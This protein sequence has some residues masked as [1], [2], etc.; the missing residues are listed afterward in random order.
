MIEDN[1]CLLKKSESTRSEKVLEVK[2]NNVR[3]QLAVEAFI[4]CC[5]D[6][7]MHVVKVV[8]GLDYCQNDVA[9]DSGIAAYLLSYRYH[10]A[11]IHG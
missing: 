5:R 6:G 3:I 10:T 9:H 1:V 2:N 4:M 11:I 7:W 8:R